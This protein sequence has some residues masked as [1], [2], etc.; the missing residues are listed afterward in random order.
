MSIVK[1]AEG[2]LVTGSHSI[3]VM[4]QNHFSQLF[5][6]Q[7]VSDLRQTEIR[8]AQPIVPELSAFEAS[9]GTHQIPAALTKAGV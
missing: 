6:V 1:D 2:D 5:S 3:M 8:T 4:W 9:L 7:G